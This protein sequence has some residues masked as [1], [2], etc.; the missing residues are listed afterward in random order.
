MDK[1]SPAA[2]RLIVGIWD[3]IYETNDIW[4]MR[5]GIGV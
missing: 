1:C 5:E 3:A 4:S 2:A